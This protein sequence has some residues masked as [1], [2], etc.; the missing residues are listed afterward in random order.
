MS[1]EPSADEA[2]RRWL[3]ALA[4]AGWLAP[5]GVEEVPVAEAAGRVLAADATAARASIAS[6]ART[7]PV[8]WATGTSS[9]PIG[10]SQPAPAS[11]SN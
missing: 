3:A 6:A 5:I 10:A 8:A 9:T 4:D 11:A 7:R 1:A 2:R